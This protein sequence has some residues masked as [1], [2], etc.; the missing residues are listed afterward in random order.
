MCGCVCVCV[1]VCVRVCISLCVRVSVCVIAGFNYADFDIR[2]IQLVVDKFGFLLLIYT[3][4]SLALRLPP[5]S[6][7]SERLDKTCD[8]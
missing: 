4:L 1:S 5:F 3:M 2:W 7:R 6:H 8:L